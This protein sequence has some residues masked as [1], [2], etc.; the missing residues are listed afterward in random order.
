MMQ[1]NPASFSVESKSDDQGKLERVANRGNEIRNEYGI[2]IDKQED[3]NDGENVN[4]N[5]S[6]NANDDQQ[7]QQERK[8][9]KIPIAEQ[10]IRLDD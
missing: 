10:L 4:E 9:N 7:L 3:E 1:T 5:V 6:D 8:D 2:E